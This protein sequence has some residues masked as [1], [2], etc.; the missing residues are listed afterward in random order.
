V[1]ITPDLDDEVVAGADEAAA[2]AGAD[3]TADDEAA[4]ADETT[5]ELGT[6]DTA[7]L[8]TAA[9]VDELTGALVVPERVLDAA[10]PLPVVVMAPVVA[11]PL[12]EAVPFRQAV[13]P[14][15]W[16]TSGEE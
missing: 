12:V 10:A 5:A 11:T 6:A 16:M 14:P 3:E 9:V 8:E 1:G 2:E 15:G 4:A 13:D 7:A